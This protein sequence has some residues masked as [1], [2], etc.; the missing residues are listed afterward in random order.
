MKVKLGYRS[1]SLEDIEDKKVYEILYNKMIQ[2]D[3]YEANSQEMANKAITKY[4]YR[5]WRDR[6]SSSL[7]L[8]F[9]IEKIMIK[10]KPQLFNLKILKE[11][12]E[13][14]KLIGEFTDYNTVLLVS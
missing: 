12:N 4:R 6:I 9:R 8:A 11:V 14:E 5:R 10:D 7:D 1:F 3:Q 2:L 13:I